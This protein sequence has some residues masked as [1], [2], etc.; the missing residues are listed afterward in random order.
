M[1]ARFQL[2]YHA[3]LIFQAAWVVAAFL[4]PWFQAVAAAL[5]LLF[6]TLVILWLNKRG[7]LV[8]PSDRKNPAPEEETEERLESTEA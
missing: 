1:K 7:K 8:T 2:S 5:P 6:P 3:R 4:L